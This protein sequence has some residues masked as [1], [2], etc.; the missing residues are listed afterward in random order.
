VITLLPHPSGEFAAQHG[1][2][3]LLLGI[4]AKQNSTGIRFHLGA[5]VLLAEKKMGVMFGMDITN[6][7]A[8][9][10]LVFLSAGQSL[11]VQFEDA[12]LIENRPAE[13]F[14]KEQLLKMQSTLPLFES[15]D[16]LLP[17]TDSSDTDCSRG[18]SR[19]MSASTVSP[20]HGGQSPETQSTCSLS[21]VDGFVDTDS[22]RSGDTN[23]SGRLS[24][25]MSA[26]S[27]L[28]FGNSKRNRTSADEC[29]EIDSN[30]GPMKS[31]SEPTMRSL[32]VALDNA[33][34]VEKDNADGVEKPQKRAS[35]GRTYSQHSTANTRHSSR[36]KSSVVDM[37]TT[38]K[39][40]KMLPPAAVEQQEVTP[41][42]VAEQHAVV[43]LQ[44]A[45]DNAKA[46]V[47]LQKANDNA[48]A[49]VEQHGAIKLQ[50]E[51]DKAKAEKE[52]NL[53]TLKNM[54][55]ECAKK[56]AAEKVKHDSKV[57]KLQIAN[58]KSKAQAKQGASNDGTVVKKLVAHF[59][60]QIEEAQSKH[61][62]ESE[63]IR[64]ADLAIH[65]EQSEVQF[66]AMQEQMTN[67]R[68]A[69]QV[70]MQKQL[71]EAN[72]RLKTQREQERL[73]RESYEEKIE[74]AR[75]EQIEVDKA[76]RLEQIEVDKAARL[77]RV[78]LDKAARL[79]RVEL[80]NS[81]PMAVK[82]LGLFNDLK[83]DL[84]EKTSFEKLLAN[85][86][87]IVAQE[88]NQLWQAAEFKNMERDKTLSEKFAKLADDARTRE[89]ARASDD[90]K[91]QIQ[92]VILYSV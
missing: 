80:E 27:T 9:T 51:K 20:S 90:Y 76:A 47:K 57:E 38:A 18:P 24:T 63:K 92:G 71:S 12:K 62:A 36:R 10:M 28:F 6:P 39:R 31:G 72:E 60:A 4:G 86:N 79:P 78:E 82:L 70:Q 45:N 55:E 33:D 61:A 32:A 81:E 88:S 68:L 84:L 69:E 42:A 75:L 49:V 15:A 2:S 19:K 26:Q 67:Q 43:D 85:N 73:T 22:S 44:K 3:K 29:S 11:R 87:K 40:Q 35:R 16:G 13:S 58:D 52:K 48:K 53:Q 54:K 30:G 37:N 83:Q 21:S 89:A 25:K 64:A 8:L 41:S 14:T 74:A 17:Q 7:Q 65:R 77:I 59:N 46:V 50:K 56:I 91:E 23:S 66:Y 5:Y 34:G 1:T